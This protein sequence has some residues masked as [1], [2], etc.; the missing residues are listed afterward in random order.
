MKKQGRESRVEK[1]GSG[2]GPFTK[3]LSKRPEANMSPF[4]FNLLN[5][6]NEDNHICLMWLL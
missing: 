5:L 6:Q 3:I 2:L 4:T 1:R